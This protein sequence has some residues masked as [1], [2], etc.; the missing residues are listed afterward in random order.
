MM[1]GLFLTNFINHYQKPF[2]DELNRIM[3][4]TCYFFE[5]ESLPE[6]RKKLGFEELDAPYKVNIGEMSPDEIRQKYGQLFM[7]A[8]FVLYNRGEEYLK[9]RIKAGRLVFYTEER[10]CKQKR[11]PYEFIR[12][13]LRFYKHHNRYQNGSFYDLGMSAYYAGDMKRHFAKTD[14]MYQ[15]AYFPE[16]VNKEP[17]RKA[18]HKNR[19][20]EMI[21]VARF[22][23]WKHPEA[24]LKLAE[25]L[26]NDGR[27]DHGNFHITMLGVGELLDRVRKDIEN[28]G[29][30]GYV[31][32]P[33]PVLVPKVREYMNA[34]DIFL[35]TSDFQEGWGVVVNEAMNSCLACVAS[36]EP[37]S[38]PVLIKS[39]ENGLIYKNG[40]DDDLYE[41]VVYLMDHPE[42][43]TEYGNKAFDTIEKLWSPEVA[44]ER[45]Y[46]AVRDIM[47]TGNCNRYSEGPMSHATILENNWIYN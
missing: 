23:D 42:K 19:R 31:D 1:T 9:E 8:D 16:S 13:Y 11:N 34:S 36:H 47:K 28:M 24:V 17:V 14:K 20:I 18:D 40:N 22:I 37:G 2:Y 26:I 7:D 21:W 46:T 44:A 41:K 33:G 25:K 12:E 35:F 30:K 6:D 5:T 29:L 15:W 3:D 38:V 27:E 45:F 43:I 4:G 10:W 39:G 32:A